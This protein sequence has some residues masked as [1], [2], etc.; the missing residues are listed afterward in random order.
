MV[1]I[2]I[3]Q[4]RAENAADLLSNLKQIGSETDNLTFGAEGLPISLDTEMD[5]IKELHLKG[6]SSFFPLQ[7][8]RDSV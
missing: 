6:W 4:A 5:H 7:F 8:A 3:R 1:E 2:I